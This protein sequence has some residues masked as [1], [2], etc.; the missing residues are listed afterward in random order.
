M[1]ILTTPCK[2]CGKPI[3]WGRTA[4]G[5]DVPLDP[6]PAT[7][8]VTGQG[9]DRYR[10]QRA[11]GNKDRAVGQTLVSHFVTCPKAALFSAAAKRRAEGA[12]P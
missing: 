5:V 2:G 9:E 3:V 1:A 10:I 11:N 7:Y 8:A 6:T 12:K 4:E